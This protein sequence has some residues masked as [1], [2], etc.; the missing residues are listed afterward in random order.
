MET[1]RILSQAASRFLCFEGSGG[2]LRAEVVILPVLSGVSEFLEDQLY[3]GGICRGWPII[4]FLY[5][6]GCN[7]LSESS[8]G[9]N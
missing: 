8:V 7:F 5:F 3:P 6:L 9:L 2:S 4:N 1:G